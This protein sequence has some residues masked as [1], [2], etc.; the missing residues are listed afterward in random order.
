MNVSS[1]GQLVFVFGCSNTSRIIELLVAVKSKIKPQKVNT[2]HLTP[3]KLKGN[4][5][6]KIMNLETTT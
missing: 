2:D 4:T 1:Y 6:M 5:K 3:Y